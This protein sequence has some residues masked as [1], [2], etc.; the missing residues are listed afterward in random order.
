MKI[1]RVKDASTVKSH[2]GEKSASWESAQEEN[3]TS[4]AKNCLT[5]EN[6]L[7]KDY[8][9]FC[10]EDGIAVNEHC[11]CTAWNQYLFGVENNAH[12]D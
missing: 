12:A 4:T 10:G 11:F 3:A 9:N 6:L 8:G 7:V 1:T 5:C 2:G